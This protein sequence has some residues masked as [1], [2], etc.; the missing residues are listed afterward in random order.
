MNYGIYN[1]SELWNVSLV[2]ERNTFLRTWAENHAVRERTSR[3]LTTIDARFENR[4][5]ATDGSR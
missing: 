1:C 2:G 4:P 3:K 5:M